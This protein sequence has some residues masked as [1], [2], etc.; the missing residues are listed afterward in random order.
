[1]EATANQLAD[2]NR[3]F[4][5]NAFGTPYM[6]R[7]PVVGRNPLAL[8]GVGAIRDA[9]SWSLTREDHSAE[10]PHPEPIPVGKQLRL[11]RTVWVPIPDAGLRDTTRAIVITGVGGNPASEGTGSNSRRTG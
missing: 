10:Y 7:T 4:G 11:G 1:M 9:G 5:P 6:C 8:A 3:H 2:L